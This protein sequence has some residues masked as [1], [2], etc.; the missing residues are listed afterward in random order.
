MSFFKNLF[1]GNDPEA[2]KEQPPVQQQQQVP[3]GQKNGLV[4]GRYTDANKTADQLSHW[5]ESVKLFGEKKYMDAHEAFFKYIRDAA[6][7]NVQFTRN[8]DRIDFTI[9]QGS[10]LIKGYS[11]PEKVS[12]EVN[13]ARFEK[14]SVAFMR[15]MMDLNFTF[16][17]SRFAF[18]DDIIC[19]KYTSHMLDASPNKMYYSLKEISTKADRQDNLLVDEFQML[20]AV[21][22]EHVE[23]E[24]DNVKEIKHKYT[25]KWI[26]DA[27][28]QAS[29]LDETKFAGAISFLLLNVAYKI[30]Y[31][32]CP[33]GGLMTDMEK[34]SGIYF[35]KDNKAIEEKNRA[36]ME[37][38]KKILARPKEFFTNSFYNTRATF[39]IVNASDQKTVAD[40]VYNEIGNTTWYAQNNYPDIVRTIYEYIPGYCFF[41][42]GM[43]PGTMAILHLLIELHNQDFFGELGF[44]PLM[45]NGIIDPEKVNARITAINQKE[46]KTYPNFNFL[47]ANLVYNGNF[48]DFC[49]SYLKEFD[50]LNLS[51]ELAPA[52]K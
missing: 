22:Q 50:F 21:D 7:D 43:Y 23:H 33:E 40:L 14:P 11:T 8:G 17:Y 19:M 20:K 12:A 44:A 9:H 24:A 13:I 10:K 32:I 34:I 1:G 25:L 38:Y 28:E 18:K 27:L 30:D 31:L 41:N 45:N 37:E 29:K 39:G 5:N 3:T 52:T 15:K 16:Q 36:I 26:T 35:A 46:V 51:K 4:F 47:P 49:A 2:P 42:Y 6:S 48:N